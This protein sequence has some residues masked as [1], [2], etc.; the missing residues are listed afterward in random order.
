MRGVQVLTP[1]DPDLIRPLTITYSDGS[2]GTLTATVH[3]K[4][5]HINAEQ[6]LLTCQLELKSVSKAM[7]E[8]I[9]PTGLDHKKIIFHIEVNQ[10]QNQF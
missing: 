8:I 4:E 9:I 10:A 2:E 7:T 6:H 1:T 3:T 5:C